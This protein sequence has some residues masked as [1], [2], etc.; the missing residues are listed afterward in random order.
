MSEVTVEQ[1][2]DRL[3]KFLGRPSAVLDEMLAI[4]E[5]NF[6]AWLA[7]H[8]HPALQGYYYQREHI[9]PGKLPVILAGMST[10]TQELTGAYLQ[11]INHVV[12][13]VIMQPFQGR[14]SIRQALDVGRG[15][16]GL[17]DIPQF[18][19][20]V[21]TTGTA[22]DQVRKQIWNVCV[23]SSLTLLGHDPNYEGVIAGFYV[24]QT[25]GSNLWS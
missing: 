6:P 3:T 18:K 8:G 12:L 22:P 5:D 2:D 13:A 24:S 20:R 9:E 25:P 15:L 11:D 17:F 7:A 19:Q 16:H 1:I 14:R 23:P 4:V 10:D 21:V